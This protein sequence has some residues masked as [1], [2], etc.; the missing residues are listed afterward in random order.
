MGQY[1]KDQ[2]NRVKEETGMILEVRGKGLM[3]GIQ[4]SK[5][6]A[7]AVNAKCLEQGFLVGNL[8]DSIIRLLP[9][10]IIR[11]EDI[12]AFIPVF[13]SILMSPELQS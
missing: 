12:D 4:L 5:P 13:R 1:L 3:I 7:K 9:P 11:K 2:L 10:L 6:V 8:G